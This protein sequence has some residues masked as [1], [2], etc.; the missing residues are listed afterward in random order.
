LYSCGW[1]ISFCD[2]VSFFIIFGAKE[3][4]KVKFELNSKV[5]CYL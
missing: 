2:V 5:V 3:L 1:I 4:I